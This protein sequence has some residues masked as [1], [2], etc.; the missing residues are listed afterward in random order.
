MHK[1]R[2]HRRKVGGGRAGGIAHGS[3]RGSRACA[4]Q[5]WGRASARAHFGPH[6]ARLGGARVCALPA[7]PALRSP[8]AGILLIP[9]RL[10]PHDRPWRRAGGG[11]CGPSAPAGRPIVPASRRSGANGTAQPPATSGATAAFPAPFLSAG[12][13]AAMPS[14]H[15]PPS[16]ASATRGP[17]QRGR[18]RDLLPEQ[19]R[20]AGHPSRCDGRYCVQ[21]HVFSAPRT[22]FEVQ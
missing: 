6:R 21:P 19:T 2:L 12:F 9:P 22:D 18:L 1:P 15:R 13:P 17:G 20:L 11:S 7:A 10:E 5:W 8:E 14:R 16:A 4:S 3:V